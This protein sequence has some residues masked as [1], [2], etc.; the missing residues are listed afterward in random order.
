MTFTKDLCV[1][2]IQKFNDPEEPDGILDIE[3]E[4]WASEYRWCPITHDGIF[5]GGRVVNLTNDLLGS[6][7]LELL[8]V[9]IN[10]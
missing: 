1:A 4:L 3:M 6:T 8:E 7:V 10:N 2:I 5:K 9:E